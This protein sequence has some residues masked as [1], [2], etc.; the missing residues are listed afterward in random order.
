MERETQSAQRGHRRVAPM[1][2]AE[3]EARGLT[4]KELSLRMRV[5]AAA[6]PANRWAVEYR[7]IQNAADGTACALDTYLALSGFFGWDFVERIQTPIHGADPIT[8][9][10]AELERQLCQ[11]AALQARLER[12]RALRAGAPGGAG[13][14]AGE[15]VG[16][17]A[18]PS[19]ERRAF[20]TR[21]PPIRS[22]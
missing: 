15:P 4:A 11:V 6:D 21:T 10:E 7:T 5:W 22:A 14:L 19:G 1:L 16:R 3:M 17:G 13:G 18:R 12:E 8:A 9:R 20:T 2:R